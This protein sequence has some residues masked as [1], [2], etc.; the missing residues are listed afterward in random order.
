[1]H[2][3]QITL[4]P[5]HICLGHHIYYVWR[6][7]DSYNLFFF[8]DLLDTL[9]DKDLKLAIRKDSHLQSQGEDC[10]AKF[11][12]FHKGYKEKFGGEHTTW[13]DVLGG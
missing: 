2:K 7:F 12:K 11:Q 1:M 13:S 4:W 10:F 5:I 6:M 9:V 8:L 3:I